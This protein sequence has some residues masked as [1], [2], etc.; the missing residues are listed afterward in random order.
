MTSLPSPSPSS[1]ACR[2]WNSDSATV[3]L[4]QAPG[5]ATRWVETTAEVHL[6]PGEAGDALPPCFGDPLCIDFDLTITFFVSY[7]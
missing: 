3:D 7:S 1:W 6:A 2:T 4:D 5:G